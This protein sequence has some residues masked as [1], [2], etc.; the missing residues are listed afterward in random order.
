MRARPRLRGLTAVVCTSLLASLVVTSCT[1]KASNQSVITVKGSDTMVILGQRWAEDYMKAHPEVRV[2]V[3]GGGS[4]TGIAALI[5]G[6]VDI[7]QSSRPMTQ[8]ER[9]DT[10]AKRGKDVI[11]TKVA[12]DALAVYVNDANPLRDVSIPALAKIF[13]GETASWKALGGEDHAIVLYGRENNSGTYAF[14][15]EHVLGGHDFATATQALAGTSALVQAVK[16]DPFGIGYGGFAYGEGIRA[17]RVKATDDSAPIAPSLETA[18]SGAYP[19]TRF[20]FFYTAGN[21][22]PPVERFIEWVTGPE[23]QGTV[24]QVGYF[25]LPRKS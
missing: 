5:N 23:G 14:F 8:A 16:R 3:N 15:R 22:P 17:L 13:T 21:P 4:G 2:E 6:S 9:L 19:L 20:L 24:S 25:P 7:C 12:L 11:E 10:R 18:N 1:R